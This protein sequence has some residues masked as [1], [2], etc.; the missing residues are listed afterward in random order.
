MSDKVLR[1]C[2][3]GAAVV[4]DKVLRGY[5]FVSSSIQPYIETCLGISGGPALPL[6]ESRAGRLASKLGQRLRV[7]TPSVCKLCI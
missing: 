2:S 3:V 5:P 6:I 7:H 4:S 1:G